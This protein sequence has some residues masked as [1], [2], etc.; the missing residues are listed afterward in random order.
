MNKREPPQGDFRDHPLSEAELLWLREASKDPFDPRVVK[1]RL[2]ER[3]PRQFDPQ[4]IDSRF[5]VQDHLTLLGLRRAVPNHP[6]LHHID[7][8]IRHIRQAIINA[9]GT[10]HFSTK[11]I[12]TATGLAEF[13]VGRAFYELAQLGRFLTSASGPPA[14]RSYTTIALSNG[15]A[16]D[17]YLRYEDL[18]TLFQKL[19]EQW[20]TSAKQTPVWVGPTGLAS[21]ANQDTA[22]A[23][24]TSDLGDGEPPG[25]VKQLIWVRK[26]VRSHPFLAVAAAVAIA[27]TITVPIGEWSSRHASATVPPIFPYYAQTFANPGPDKLACGGR[28]I[29][30]G[31]TVVVSLAGVWSEEPAAPGVVGFSPGSSEWRTKIVLVGFGAKEVLS[32]EN[33]RNPSILTASKDT[34]VCVQLPAPNAG[35]RFKMV[36]DLQLCV[37]DVRTAAVCAS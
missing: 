13:D 12:A 14:A 28:K 1:V 5:Y 7:T 33:Y 3:L 21:S 6:L 22:P 24:A 23:D 4:Q 8:V 2:L 32:S 17:A 27:V 29:P 20:A 30:A 36:E 9:P 10:E 16:Y 31:T 18:D 37:A 34:D 19:Y 25:I 26:N 15:V 11:D 35:H